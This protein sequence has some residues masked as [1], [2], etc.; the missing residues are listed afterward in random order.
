MPDQK[1]TELTLEEN[2]TADAL[3]YVVDDPE[4]TPVDR[5]VKRQNLGVISNPDSGEYRIVNIRLDAS[6]HI[7]ITYDSVPVV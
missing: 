5:K 2:P 3:V 1:L 4:G 6:K 7:V